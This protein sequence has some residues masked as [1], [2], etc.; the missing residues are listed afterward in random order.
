[1][2][3]RTLRNVLLKPKKK[4]TKSVTS[5]VRKTLVKVQP[6]KKHDVPSIVKMIEDANLAA[7]KPRGKYFR[8][9]MLESCDRAN[10][11]H[12]LDAPYKAP[13]QN[14]KMQR[15]LDVGTAIHELIQ[16]KYLA[17]SWEY[18]FVKEAPS[19][20]ILHGATV[21]GH[22]D[23]ILIERNGRRRRFCVEIK[24]I[25]GSLF[26]LLT[27]PKP[28]HVKQAMNYAVANDCEGIIFLYWDKNRSALKEYYVPISDEKADI[29]RKNTAKRVKHL[30]LMADKFDDSLD[31]DD[32]PP[33]NK[34]TC[35][36][37]FCGY[38]RYCRRQGAPV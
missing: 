37:A 3:S 15:T 1:M 9:S 24:T 14:P 28:E 34:S 6:K 4:K 18:Y 27:K 16:E 26:K 33:Y 8:P 20:L 19:R 22:T 29:V 21:Q 23:G 7:Q 30:K 32:L 2:L 13:P 35:Y 5:T 10:V 38:I 31:P 12:Y 25:E 36:K 17:H 11:F